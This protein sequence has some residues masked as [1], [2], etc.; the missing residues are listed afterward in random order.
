MGHRCDKRRIRPINDAWLSYCV[1]CGAALERTVLGKWTLIAD[2]QMHFAVHPEPRTVANPFAR[3]LSVK[4]VRSQERRPDPQIAFARDLVNSIVPQLRPGSERRD[5][6]IVRAEEARLLAEAAEEQQ[7]KVIHLEMAARYYSL[8]NFHL[9][10]PA[11]MSSVESRQRTV[12]A[13]DS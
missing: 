8:A 3:S 2:G 11:Q 7:I 5:Y 4:V 1:R 6:Y 10:R 12:K 13:V 9:E